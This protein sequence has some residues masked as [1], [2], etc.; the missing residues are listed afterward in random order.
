ML[1]SAFLIMKKSCPIC[2]EE[3]E[4]IASASEMPSI[5]FIKIPDWIREVDIY[6]CQN[7]HFVGMWHEG[8]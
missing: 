4:K 2:K 5:P 3:M 7:C 8:K 1:P 6:E